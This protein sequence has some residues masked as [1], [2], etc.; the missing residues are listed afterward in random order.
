[1]SFIAIIYGIMDFLTRI[2]PHPKNV[3]PLVANQPLDIPLLFFK[4]WLLRLMVM[5]ERNFS[6]SRHSLMK[7]GNK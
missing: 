7:H 1:M 3:S 2:P 4:P 6:H 5:I